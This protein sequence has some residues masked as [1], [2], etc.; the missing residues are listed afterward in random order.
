MLQQA[1]HMATKIGCVFKGTAGCEC[2]THMAVARRMTLKDP[3][4]VHVQQWFCPGTI[5]NLRL[6]SRVSLVVWDRNTDRGRQIIGETE[7]L[8]DTGGTDCYFPRSES[9]SLP[10]ND[11]QLIIKVTKV[12]GFTQSA[13]TD[14][15]V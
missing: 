2:T 10:Q 12:V 4:T 15:G 7:R 11:N 9:R 1:T 5:D 8:S 3:E 13:H 14:A 6:N